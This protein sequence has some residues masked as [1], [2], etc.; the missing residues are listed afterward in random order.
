MDF[1]ESIE[2]SNVRFFAD[3]REDLLHHPI[4]VGLRV[5]SFTRRHGEGRR[6]TEEE[7]LGGQKAL[8]GDSRVE[9]IPYLG[10]LT[11]VATPP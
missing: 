6:I 11:Q 1:Y 4:A 10:L 9:S 8:R 7:G 3:F 5:N 2:R